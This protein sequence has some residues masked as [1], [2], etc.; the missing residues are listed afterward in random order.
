MQTHR[1]LTEGSIHAV[2]V[3]G[4]QEIDSAIVLLRLLNREANVIVKNFFDRSVAVRDFSGAF[5]PLN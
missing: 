2:L 3:A 5:E 4:D 1:D